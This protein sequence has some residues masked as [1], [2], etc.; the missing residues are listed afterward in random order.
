MT[1]N[2][3]SRPEESLDSD[4]GQR[5]GYA[6]DADP[7]RPDSERCL[8]VPGATLN[9]PTTEGPDMH[10]ET[11]PDFESMSPRALGAA[12]FELTTAL[13]RKV[14]HDEALRRLQR[15]G[16]ASMDELDDELAELLTAV[17]G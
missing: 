11:T 3:Q 2:P 9:F 15:H 17:R 12:L 8:S 10:A 13:I 4:A 7:W 6:F 16:I 5:G 14:G 1:P